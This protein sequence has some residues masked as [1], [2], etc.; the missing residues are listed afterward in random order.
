MHPCVVDFD[1]VV[2]VGVC[3]VVVVDIAAIVTA[4]WTISE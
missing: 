4:T 2:V 1:V 3:V